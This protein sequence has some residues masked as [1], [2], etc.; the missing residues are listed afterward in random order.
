MLAPLWTAA[1]IIGTSLTSPAP[2]EPLAIEPACAY[3]SDYW[4][5]QE[6]LIVHKFSVGGM[7]SVSPSKGQI[8]FLLASNRQLTDR[9]LAL[10]SARRGAEELLLSDVM[11]QSGK[12]D[13][14]AFN[15]CHQNE[16]VNFCGQNHY[17]CSIIYQELEAKAI[18]AA[19][20]SNLRELRLLAAWYPDRVRID[21]RSRAVYLIDCSGDIGRR[22][23]LS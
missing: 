13:C 19:R 10:V 16:Q 9:R 22:L 12:Y 17:A 1:L 8:A 20:A 2:S 21:S 3:C 5:S 4:S 6:G 14:A 15:A 23:K 18:V 7:A 11:R